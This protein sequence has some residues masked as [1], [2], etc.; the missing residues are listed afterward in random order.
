[1]IVVKDAFGDSFE[2]FIHLSAA[3]VLQVSHRI[4]YMKRF[5]LPK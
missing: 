1:M 5:I 4:F 3:H 2:D